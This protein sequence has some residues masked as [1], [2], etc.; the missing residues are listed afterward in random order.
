MYKVFMKER[1]IQIY[2]KKLYALE[3]LKKSHQYNYML[4]SNVCLFFLS[5]SITFDQL[6]RVWESANRSGS[7]GREILNTED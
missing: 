6:Y 3:V 4:W 7:N 5:S 1:Q 2:G